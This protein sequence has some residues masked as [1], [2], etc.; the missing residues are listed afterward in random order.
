MP[1]DPDGWCINQTEDLGDGASYTS[2]ASSAVSL[3]TNG[4][5]LVQRK[6]V[7]TGTVNGVKRRVLLTTNAATGAPLFPAN[8]AAVSL[9]SVDYGN[10][11]FINGGVGSNGNITLR[12]TA[13]V[14]GAATPGPG[15]TLIA[16]KQRHRM[17]WLSDQLRDDE[18]RVRSRG[19]GHVG[20][21]ERQ[22]PH[23]RG[24]HLHRLA[25]PGTRRPGR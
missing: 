14:C 19:P 20:D 4:Q 21:P 25:S 11:V 23:L 5:L 17:S 3:N 15:K 22:Q 24:G 6:I 8:Y 10:S 7:S 13:E 12:N 2:R 18:L 1:V 16:A 9:S